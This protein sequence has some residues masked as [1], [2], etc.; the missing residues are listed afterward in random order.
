MSEELW[1]ILPPI[2]S[3]AFPLTLITLFEGFL[4]IE[5][6]TFW[7]SIQNSNEL[8]KILTFNLK[9]IEWIRVL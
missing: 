3:E 2:S 4:G 7:I 6:G 8:L 9:K 5:H 1:L